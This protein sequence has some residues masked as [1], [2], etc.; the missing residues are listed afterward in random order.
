LKEWGNAVRSRTLLGLVCMVGSLVACAKGADFAGAA[1]NG[2]D[3]AGA[4]GGGGGKGG[5]TGTSMSTGGGTGTTT[6]TTTSTG[7]TTG[8][9]TTTTTTTTACADSPCKLA[10]PQCGC[11]AG[12][13]CTL[14]SALNRECHAAGDV[15]VGQTCIGIYD[16]VAGGFCAGVSQT[17][18]YC[19]QLC[20]ND[21]T[22]GNA[23]CVIQLVDAQQAPIPGVT[24]CSDDCD[25]ITSA[26]CG[27]GLGCSLGQEP[28][29]QMR[30]FGVCRGAGAKKQGDACTGGDCAVGSACFTLNDMAMSMKCLQ[31][32]KVGSGVCSA[33]TTCKAFPTPAIYK[34]TEYGV[35]I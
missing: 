24:L 29:G 31:Y 2:G 22:C 33:G 1:G 3:G 10:P 32:C 7:T 13:M 17:Q 18:S 28:D 21:A 20:D 6:D 4:S 11:D 23:I 14:D 35:C 15:G 26:G 25:P 12:D 27:S 16:C 19:A 8:T 5:G 9:T 30:I 34:G